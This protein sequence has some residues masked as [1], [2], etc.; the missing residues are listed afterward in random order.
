MKAAITGITGLRN[1]GVEAM[2]AVTIDQLI[3]YQ[4]DLIIDVLTETP[5]YDQA[6]L[7][8]PQQVNFINRHPTKGLKRWI[9]NKAAKFYKPLAPNYHI[10]SEASVAIASGGDVFSS[11]Y[12][13]AFLMQELRPLQ[14]ALAA[15]VPVVFSAHS[16]G[17]FKAEAEKEAWLSVARYAK[18]V[19]VRESL[20]YHYVTQ[21][22]GLPE[23]QVEHTADPAFLLAPPPPQ[24][25]AEL[26]R[27]Y[28]LKDDRP[29]VAIAASQGITKY[30]GSDQDNHL[31]TWCQLI[32][33]ILEE[34]DAQILLVPHVQDIKQRNDDRILATHILRNL[35]FDAR[36]RLVGGNHSAAEF[37]G[38]I[39]ACDLVIAER[40][41]A[42]IA[43]LSS[44]VC[45]VPIGYSVK[46]EGIMTDLLGE[47]HRGL[48]ISFPEFLNADRACALVHAAW[49][50]RQA[51]SQQL[52]QVMPQTVQR[53][54]RNFELIAQ[55]LD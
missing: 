8:H 4:P 17:P 13:M 49:N 55:L 21:E 40:M 2:V 47:D 34:L 31:K 6:Q 14:L 26:L 30:T 3:Q 29:I 19:T 27:Y 32:C 25:I 53:A 48:L 46:A 35:S 36:I 16:I 15:N 11:D 54:K 38:L 50:R 12:G 39:G 42:C 37:K 20:S 24:R 9:H 18:L 41:H 43:G 52:K 5:D 22:L 51:V 45:T 1:R 7:Q 23:T 28:N 33:M 44:H 10:L